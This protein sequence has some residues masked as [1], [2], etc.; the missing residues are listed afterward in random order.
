MRKLT[1]CL[2]GIAFSFSLSATGDSLNYLTAKDTVFLKMDDFGNSIFSHK[3][4]RGQ[5]MYSLSNFYGIKL[6]ILYNFNPD[7]ASDGTVP[8]GKLVNVIVPD[9]AIVDW[10][11]AWPRK[12]FVPVFVS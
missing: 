11:M 7:L 10:P 1:L 12:D 8:P 2:L 9:S 4:A 3:L 5:T 6:D